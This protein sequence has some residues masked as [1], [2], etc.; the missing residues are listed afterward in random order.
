VQ[1]FKISAPGILIVVVVVFVV[2]V[3]EEIQ[4]SRSLVD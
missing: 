4:S 1:G 2:V 3:F